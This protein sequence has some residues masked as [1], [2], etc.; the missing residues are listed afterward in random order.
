MGSD[1]ASY[2]LSIPL[3]ELLSLTHISFLGHVLLAASIKY[4]TVLIARA[5]R[6][7]LPSNEAS[8]HYLWKIRK[9]T[10]KQSF[11]SQMLTGR[12]KQTSKVASVAKIF[13]ALC[14][15]MENLSLNW[16]ILV[17]LAKY[18]RCWS[19]RWYSRFSMVEH[20]FLVISCCCI[21]LTRASKKGNDTLN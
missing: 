12:Q 1:T 11:S 20:C 5:G 10:Y 19:R 16:F 18:G 14:T 6:E 15:H 21:K 4:S 8:V 17:T 13:S 3:H 2:R 9:S 7:S